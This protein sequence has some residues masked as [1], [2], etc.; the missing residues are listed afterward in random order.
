[1]GPEF[2]TLNWLTKNYYIPS[3]NK[4]QTRVIIGFDSTL[5]SKNLEYKDKG[6]NLQA[7]KF[8]RSDTWRKKRTN[9]HKMKAAT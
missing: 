1:M 2:I 4:K 3:I 5:K 7:I 8:N 9:Y 6:I